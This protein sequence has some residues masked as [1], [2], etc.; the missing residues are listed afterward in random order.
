MKL[1]LFDIDGTLIDPYGAGSR[2]A[3]KAFEDLFSI[4]DAFADIRMA[5]KTDIQIMKEG[6]TTHGLSD[7][8]ELLSSIFQAYLDHLKREVKIN[9]GK[10]KPGVRDLLDALDKIENFSLGL[11]TGNIKMGARIK[12]DAFGLNHYFPSG[13]FGDDDEDRNK[14]LPFAVRRYEKIT[15]TS[16]PYSNCIVIGDTPMDVMCSKPFGSKAV[17]V[18]TGP[19]SY[20]TLTETRADY[21]IKDLTVGLEI[22]RKEMEE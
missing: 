14:L 12:L 8:D 1:I 5:G 22:I 18:S 21:V 6:L 19:Y 20:E 15:E 11:L 2:S 9:K 17:A 4:K 10:L 3:G 7:G 16:I 13:A